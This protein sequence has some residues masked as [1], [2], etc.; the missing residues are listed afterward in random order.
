[1]ANFK[2]ISRKNWKTTTKTIKQQQNTKNQK[3][4]AYFGKAGNEYTLARVPIAASDFSLSVYSYDNT[5]DDF[6]LVNF[7]LGDE[8][9]LYKIPTIQR[10]LNVSTR[11]VKLF[12]TP[13]SAPG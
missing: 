2:Q 5:T 4:N 6:D 7:A 10:A 13:W 8:D 3:I 12:A 9:I 11:K 1:M